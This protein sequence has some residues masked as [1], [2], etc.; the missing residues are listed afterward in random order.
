[1]KWLH[2]DFA[3]IE[4]FQVLI[5]IDAHSKWIKATHTPLRMQQLRQFKH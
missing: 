3:E 1:M 5:I 4:G 2:I